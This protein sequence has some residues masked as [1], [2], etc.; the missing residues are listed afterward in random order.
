MPQTVYEDKRKA[1]V[2][3]KAQVL[4]AGGGISGITAAIVAKKLGL[5]VILTERYGFLG[6]ISTAGL[7]GTFCGFYTVDEN[8]SLFQVIRGFGDELLNRLKRLDAIG[9]VRIIDG[10]AGIIPYDSTSLR[11]VT[12]QLIREY[13]IKIYLHSLAVSVNQENGRLKSVIYESKSGCFAIESETFIDATGDG[14]IAANA[15]AQYEINPG[16]TQF[17]TTIFCIG[18][19]DLETANAFKREVVADLMEKSCA[20]GE[21]NL[22]RTDA[23]MVVSPVTGEIRCNFTRV[24]KDGRPVNGLDVRE[25]SY[26]EMEGR[27]QALEYLRFLKQKVP[28]FEKACISQLPVML[29]VRE[30]RRIV[31][32]YQLNKEDVLSARKFDDAIGCNAWPIEFHQ[33]GTNTHWLWLPKG[34]YYQIPYRCL[35]VKGVSNLLSI[36]RCLSA[37]QEAQASSR[38]I[39]SCINQGEAAAVACAIALQDRCGLR[40]VDFGKLKFKL[41]ELGAYLG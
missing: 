21:F 27:L 7:L 39:A 6:G 38:I 18:N 23:R 26:G 28:G 14:D 34:K 5:D 2:I 36:G 10:K 35:R 3:D 37:T 17:P 13:D 12:D 22:P 32:D 25:L 29:G 1:A 41:Q 8:G 19:V 9:P 11:I 30:T 4:I 16:K 33:S 15:G 20:N 24:G 31:G 40:D